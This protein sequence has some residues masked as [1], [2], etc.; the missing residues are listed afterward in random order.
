MIHQQ[1][2]YFCCICYQQANRRVWPKNEVIRFSNGGHSVKESHILV[3]FINPLNPW[4]LGPISFLSLKNLNEFISGHSFSNPI[5]Y[6]SSIFEFIYQVCDLGI[7]VVL[8]SISPSMQFLHKGIQPHGVQFRLGLFKHL[9]PKLINNLLEFGEL[10]LSFP[11]TKQSCEFG[12]DIPLVCI[13]KEGTPS[14]R[15]KGRCCT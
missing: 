7:G 2:L 15:M 13:D 3:T 9:R 10:R 14:D 11:K 6:R 8:F 1:S 4:P 12:V 5:L